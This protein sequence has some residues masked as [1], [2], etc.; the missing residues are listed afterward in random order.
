MKMT[1]VVLRLALLSVALKIEKAR[2]I[3]AGMTGNAHFSSPVPALDTV[4]TLTNELEAAQ[5]AALSGG[6]EDTAHRN[7][8]E[9]ELELALKTLAAYVETVANGH[10]ALAEEIVL[11][12][13]MTVKKH[14]APVVDDFE[15][16]STGKPGQIRVRKRHEPFTFVIVQMTATPGDESTWKTIRSSSRGRFTM[17]G[18][19][20]G[21]RYYF[22]AAVYA[23]DGQRPW[24]EVKSALAL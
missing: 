11:S 10:P 8:K 23:R 15:V 3:V 1:N 13:G 21:T 6:P 17:S 4:N 24:T 22:R 14:T 2:S 9:R 16:K 19:T 12:A 20:S 18:L 7:V 5:V